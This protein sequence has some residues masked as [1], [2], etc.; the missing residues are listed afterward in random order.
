MN[1]HYHAKV[2]EEGIVLFYSERAVMQAV[3][4]VPLKNKI[5]ENDIISFKKELGHVYFI[6]NM[7]SRKPKVKQWES[8]YYMLSCFLKPLNESEF[9]QH[10]TK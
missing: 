5:N 8:K 1:I 3:F 2:N 10:I 4:R 7:E 9:K 6:E